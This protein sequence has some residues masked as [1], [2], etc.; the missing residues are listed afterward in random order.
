ME[1]RS[2]NPL[3]RELARSA[4]AEPHPD[5]D[6]LTA[7]AE[8]SLV[9]REQRQV[10]GH[11]ARCVEC[12]EVVALATAAMPEPAMDR[13]LAQAHASRRIWGMGFWTWAGWTGAAALVALTSLPGLMHWQKAQQ[14][15]QQTA[16]VNGL[17]RVP[18]TIRAAP[19][20]QP[21]AKAEAMVEAKTTPSRHAEKQEA[22]PPQAIP[23]TTPPMAENVPASGSPAEAG[24]IAS[25]GAPSGS[26]SFEVQAPATSAG[27]VSRGALAARNG[28]IARGGSAPRTASSFSRMAP[29]LSLSQTHYL[30]SVPPRWRI[31]ASGQAER[32]LAG[33]G[34]E[35]VLAGETAKMRV[36][37]LV[38]GAVW[39]GG[40][41]SRLY[42]S[43]DNGETW[44]EV[45]LPEKNGANHAIVHVVFQGSEE[46]TI[47]AEDGTVWR[48]EDGGR[49][50]E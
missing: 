26:T 48:T 29:S 35:R 28:A 3:E 37:S 25:A 24:G 12:R 11:L 16:A 44:T 50:W 1:Q 43:G 31:D 39:I 18:A 46:G 5:A 19:P 8:G 15:K 21:A 49:T 10:L 45:A 23:P 22:A 40:E 9:A 6:Q 47:S 32:L 34:W 17:A 2:I 38:G 42:R 4:P 36:V 7:F 14:G 30:A 13:A 41:N 27:N 33:G 20:A